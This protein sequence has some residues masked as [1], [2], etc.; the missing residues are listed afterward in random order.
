VQIVAFILQLYLLILL[1]RIVLSW[2]PIASGGAMAG[3]QRF[4]Y[5]LTEPVL[6][7]IR[8]LLPPVRFGAVGIDLSPIIL[9]FGLTILIGFLGRF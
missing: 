3:V 9:L 5:A 2:F 7:P 8:A 4:C 1:G 6:A